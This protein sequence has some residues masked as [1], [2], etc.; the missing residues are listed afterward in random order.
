MNKYSKKQV[1]CLLKAYRVT[2][3]GMETSSNVQD[4]KV[5]RLSTQNLMRLKQLHL[6]Q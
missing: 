5:P 2:Q 1:T 6:Q 3:Q 4:G